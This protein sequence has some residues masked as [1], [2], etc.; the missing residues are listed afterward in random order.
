M[1]LETRL[2]NNPYS[3]AKRILK[4]PAQMHIL[5]SITPLVQTQNISFHVN[6][7]PPNNSKN[8]FLKNKIL[9]GL[10]CDGMKMT[11]HRKTQLMN[12]LKGSALMQ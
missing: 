6:T 12:L 4:N 3:N 9:C 10:N 2:A 8:P 7:F 11:G 5:L 1:I